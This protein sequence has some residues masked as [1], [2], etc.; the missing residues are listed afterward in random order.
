VRT[1]GLAIVLVADAVVDHRPNLSLRG[2][3]RQHV[4]YG[5][6]SLRFRARY[7]RPLGSPSF[8]R[9]LVQRGF[10]AGPAVG[11]LVLVAQAAAA[12]GVATERASRLRQ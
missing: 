1:R 4:R 8:Y 7:Q 3:V 11:V 5:R 12:L 6:G 10:R 2:F 9:D